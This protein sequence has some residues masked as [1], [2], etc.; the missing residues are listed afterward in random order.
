MQVLDEH[1]VERAHVVGTSLGGMVAQELALDTR[2]ASRGS[3]S[4]ARS[5]GGAGRLPDARGDGEA[6]RRGADAAARTS[7]CAA[8]SRTP[9]ARARRGRRRALRATAREP[10]GP[11]GLAGA[12]A[13]GATYANDRA[14]A[15]SRRRRSSLAGDEDNVV[16]WRNSQLLAQAIPNARL[17]M[18]AGRRAPLLLGA[19]G[20][21]ADSLKGS[22]DELAH[23]D[24]MLRDR[25]RSTPDRV[26]IDD[27]GGALDVRR[28]RRA[29]GRAR[30]ASLERT[31]T[32]S[33]R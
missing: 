15:R 23:V 13:A 5:P 11:G 17:E 24:R 29:L 22:S 1:G 16:D 3:R 4:C 31:A 32:A 8:S 14:R 7:R 25:A 27:A 30:R 12:G 28:A 18:F 33:R 20:E 26:A 9:R 21:V 19:A 6:V 10:A 2:T